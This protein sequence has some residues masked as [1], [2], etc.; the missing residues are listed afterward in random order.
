MGGCASKDAISKTAQSPIGIPA[1]AQKVIEEEEKERLIV[2][3]LLDTDKHVSKAAIN[4]ND[5]QLQKV[6]GHGLFGEVIRAVYHSTPVIVK[7]MLRNQI[8]EK[9]IRIFREEIQL[10]MNLRHPNIVQVLIIFI[11]TRILLSLRD[12]SNYF[13]FVNSLLELVGINL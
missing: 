6:I 4:Y 11:L 12:A 13:N 2:Q 10:M 3:N 7:R 9:S 8:K 5:L 1:S